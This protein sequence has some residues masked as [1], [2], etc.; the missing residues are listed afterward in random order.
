MEIT[1]NRSQW[2]LP[3]S[4]CVDVLT[5]VGTDES[6]VNPRPMALVCYPDETNEDSALL[7]IVYAVGE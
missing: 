5:N 3:G 6:P 7:H 1:D 4:Y 2:H